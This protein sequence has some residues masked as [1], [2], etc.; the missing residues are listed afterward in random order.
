MNLNEVC[1]GLVDFLLDI[2]W[3]VT[4]Y[5]SSCRAVADSMDSHVAKPC[6]LCTV[7]G[8]KA[9]A[10]NLRVENHGFTLVTDIFARFNLGIVHFTGC[11]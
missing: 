10:V 11:H 5:L 9:E 1:T 2:V 8:N 6:F 4:G 3:V 7:I